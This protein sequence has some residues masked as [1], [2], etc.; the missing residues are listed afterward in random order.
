MFGVGASRPRTRTQR[1][2]WW[3]F[4]SLFIALVGCLL[5]RNGGVP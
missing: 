1:V 2:V 5:F 4:F 3:I